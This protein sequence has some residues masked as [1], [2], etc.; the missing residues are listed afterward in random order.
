MSRQS[1]GDF[2]NQSVRR[3]RV[4]V[5]Y[6]RQD[7]E[8]ANGIVDT[9]RTADLDVLIDTRSLPFGEEWKNE[10]SHLIRSADAVVWLLTPA[11]LTSEWVN[12]ELGECLSHAKKIV[13]VRLAEIDQAGVPPGLA[14]LHIL[15]SLGLFDAARDSNALV[16]AIRTDA[17]WT[18]THTRL[19]ELADEWL[20]KGRRPDRLLRGRALRDAETWQGERPQSLTSIDAK[21]VDLLTASRRRATL[22]TRL[23][24]GFLA[25]IGIVATSL[26]IATVFLWRSSE[27]NLQASQENYRA[28]QQ[29]LLSSRRAGALATARSADLA[30]LNDIEI[31]PVRILYPLDKVD[32]EIAKAR[33]KID[34]YIFSSYAL[35]VHRMEGRITCGAYAGAEGRYVLF[36]SSGYKV[37]ERG[38]EIASGAL[39]DAIGVAGCSGSPV[40][41]VVYVG[42]LDGRLAKVTAEATSS[43]QFLKWQSGKDMRF[44]DDPIQAVALSPSGKHLAVAVG[45]QLLLIDLENHETSLRL[46]EYDDLVT[47]VAFFPNGKLLAGSRDRRASMFDVDDIVAAARERRRPSDDAIRDV[48]IDAPIHAVAASSDGSRFAVG[49]TLGNVAV[50]KTETGTGSEFR[51]GYT[52]VLFLAFGRSD[53][54]LVVG[55]SDGH[56]KVF[57]AYKFDQLLDRTLHKVD[58]GFFNDGLSSEIARSPRNDSEFL[59]AAGADSG[60]LWN[61][62]FGA[63]VLA[64]TDFP[65]GPG[66]RVQF[67]PNEKALCVW[68]GG[69]T[70]IG[71]NTSPPHLLDIASG[72]ASGDAE[73]VCKL[74]LT[75][76]EHTQYLPKARKLVDF[77]NVGD[78]SV[79]EIPV[80]APIQGVSKTDPALTY[81]VSNGVFSI[82]RSQG[83]PYRSQPDSK[84]ILLLGQDTVVETNAAGETFVTYSGGRTFGERA[85]SGAP[86]QMTVTPDRTLLE[87]RIHEASPGSTFP[88][89]RLFLV[90][91]HRD[92]SSVVRYHDPDEAS[93][94]YIFGAGLDCCTLTIGVD[95]KHLFYSKQGG[96]ARV[97]LGSG[98]PAKGLMPELSTSVSDPSG[99]QKSTNFFLQSPKHPDRAI[100]ISGNGTVRL[101]NLSTAEVLVSIAQLK[102]WID[103]A[104]GGLGI[105]DAALAGDGKKL[106]LAGWN[107][108]VVFEL[109]IDQESSEAIVEKYVAAHP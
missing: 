80:S 94:R 87:Y 103:N 105:V 24:T 79:L 75:G 4:F 82:T 6:S 13:P 3:Q 101:W 107:S 50:F 1:V 85:P 7:S 86:Y 62:D 28:S 68:P 46:S 42:T 32:P 33:S 9:L 16:D 104:S 17:R 106:A 65:K 67:A 34:D 72:I 31:E 56:V 100:T 60:V 91:P 37:F 40:K 22:R 25:S 83:E 35:R 12:W 36:A 73:G 53:D 93:G 18:R 29:N 45:R 98:R 30:N 57:D 69:P 41:A 51:A 55:A 96:I 109:P 49:D 78:T 66:G 61:F 97:D 48:T 27:E 5:S 74:Q 64:S 92:G 77:A 47:S 102:T 71:K 11:S 10:L 76:T 58:V 108:A 21:V 89:G 39:G 81:A 19:T 8:A 88:V 38:R 26:A 52:L 14:R 84:S 54:L 99:L 90:L 44:G 95:G 59:T 15:P 63:A 43:L 20:A 2:V 23:V 70:L